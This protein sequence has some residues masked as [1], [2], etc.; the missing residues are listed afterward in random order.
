MIGRRLVAP[1]LLLLSLACLSHAQDAPEKKAKKTAKKTATVEELAEKAKPSIVVILHTG[2]QGKQAGLGTGFVVSDDGLIATNFHVIGEGRPITVQMPD[3]TKHDVVSV[4]ASDRHLDLAI[5]RIAAK[6]LKPL[7]IGDS[8]KLKSGQPIT[9]LGHPQGLKYSVVAGVLSGKRDIEGV[10]MLQIA[11]PIEQ[12]NSGGPVLD[13]FGRVVGVVSMKSLVTA[14]L[15]F[16]VPSNFVQTLLKKPN[17]VPMERW[18]TLGVLDKT[19]WKS[20]Y[21]GDWRRR[22]GHITANG[23]GT[24][25]GGRSLCFWQHQPP[26]GF[27]YEITVTVKLDNESGA[28]GLFFGGDDRDSHFGFYP[29]GGKLRFT[30]FAGPDV[31]SWK[32]LDEFP[33]PYY[34]SGDW[35]TLKVHVEKDRVICF[36][37]DQQVLDRGGLEWFG[38]HLGLAKFRETVAEYKRFQVAKSVDRGP[39]SPADTKRLEAAIASALDGKTAVAPFA[40]TPTDSMKLL[41]DR[42]SQLEKQAEQLRKLAQAVHQEGVLAELAKLAQADEKK[43]D[44]LRGTL[45]IARLDNEDLEIEPYVREVARM[46]NEIRAGLP[47]DADGEAKLEALNKYLFEQHGFH[48][49]RHDYYSR[50]NSY[51]NEVIDDREGLPITLSVLYLELARR[52]D[53]PVVG[54]GLPGH[55]VVRYEPAGLPPYLID[56][57]EG[58][59]TM[60]KFEA[61]ERIVKNTGQLPKQ[62]DFQSATKKSILHRML[63]NLLGLADND[64]DRPAM[65]RY[66]DAMLALNPASHEER[67]VRAVLR[68]QSGMTAESLADC[69][70]LLDNAN[71][72]EV[73][74]DRVRELR[75]RLQK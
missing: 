56:V 55:F 30:R 45:L 25:F 53:L 42:A 36:L 16:A 62:K 51:L 72:D 1:A 75:R 14:N 7:E 22:A 74:L 73:D 64:K 6:G 9:V 54:V 33:S 63:S 66:L 59:K 60:T 28:A 69:D 11:T 17:P 24:G 5:I 12:G 38:S 31:Y 10:E 27:P 37:N 49:S 15:G 40:K 57:F 61:Q 50:N 65:L 41:R 71:E 18:V 47:K 39:L 34:R 21:G 48:G 43:L 3:G 68:F 13:N 32:I 58:G 35:N 8:D 52:L 67:W 26:K 46:A 23:I 2:R 70:H 19:E 29:S 4:H 44:L 20:T